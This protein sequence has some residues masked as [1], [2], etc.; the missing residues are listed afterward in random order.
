M[1]KV[2]WLMVL[3]VTALAFFGCGHRRDP[4]TRQDTYRHAAFTG[5]MIIDWRQS[6]EIANHPYWYDANP[7]LKDQ[8]AEFV[9]AYFATTYAL[10]TAAAVAIPDEYWRSVLQSFGIAIEAG[11]VGYNFAVGVNGEW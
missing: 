7:I 3:L 9:D 6:R 4:W 2:A 8:S 11:C 10:F 1:K 5:F